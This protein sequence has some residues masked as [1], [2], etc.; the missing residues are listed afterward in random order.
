MNV[1]GRPRPGLAEPTAPKEFHLDSAARKEQLAAPAM[2]E[3]ASYKRSRNREGGK[4]RRPQRDVAG[5]VARSSSLPIRID[6][7]AANEQELLALRDS[8][9]GDLI[10][11]LT[12]IGY[13]EKNIDT[14][15]ILILIAR[16]LPIWG[17]TLPPSRGRSVS[18]SRARRS[19]S[20]PVRPIVRR[21]LGCAF[22]T[23]AFLLLGEEALAARPYYG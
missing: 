19:A 1:S 14:Q 17:S 3:T 2:P 7:S 20:G 6:L 11:G 10:S 5:V 9:I 23:T 15:Y 13:G 4:K 8:V 21:A 22:T 16:D 18:L 12:Q